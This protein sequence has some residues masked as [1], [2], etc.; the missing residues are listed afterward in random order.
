MNF[1]ELLI[2][3]VG[4]SMDTFAVGICAGLTMPKVTSK[5]ALIVG[6][7]FGGFQA[8]MPLIGYL[9]ATLFADRVMD[10]S[11][12]IAFGL[13]GFIGCKMII[14]SFK[15]EKNS[16]N[17]ISLKPVVMLP[18][19]V[20]TSID[21]LAVG[22]SFTFLQVNI[23]PAVIIIGVIT[24]IISM[25]GVKIGNVFGMKFK[26]KAEFFGGFI[27]ITIGTRL[28]LEHLGVLGF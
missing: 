22:V 21:A 14:G 8:A 27:L 5:K 12:P 18:L 7:Y 28:L 19:A 26:S 1:I 9:G 10:Y 13:L 23:I 3:A 16:D 6:L 2:L 11:H 4:L 15:K 25:I 24:L 20:A 17:E